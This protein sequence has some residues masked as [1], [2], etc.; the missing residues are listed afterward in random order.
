MELREKLKEKIQNTRILEDQEPEMESKAYKRLNGLLERNKKDPSIINNDKLM[1]ILTEYT[2]V[3]NAYEKISK[4]KGADTPGTDPN[5]IADG[6]N[7]ETLEKL[8]DDIK[9]GNFQWSNIRKINIPKPKS[10]KTRPLGMINNTDKIVQEMIRMVLNAIYEPVFQEYEWNHGFRPNRGANTA[11]LKIK[12]E[13]KGMTSAIEGDIKGA[14]VNRKILLNILKKKITDV[15]FLKLIKDGLEAGVIEDG[16]LIHSLTGVPQGGIASPILFNIYMHEFDTAITQMLDKHLKEINDREQ[17]QEKEAE[18][19]AHKE[20]SAEVTKH[21]RRIYAIKKK[22]LEKIN[23]KIGINPD[24]KRELTKHKK[25]YDKAIS[26]RLRTKAIS[27]KRKLL[28]ASYT[29]YADHWIITT[30]ASIEECRSIKELIQKWLKEN[31]KLELNEEKTLIT[32]LFKEKARFLGFKIYRLKKTVTRNIK[33]KS[34]WFREQRSIPTM[35]GIDFERVL[36]KLEQQ[37]IVV[38]TKKGYEPTH[39]SH[40]LRQK[41]YEIVEHYKHKLIGLIN[42][43][44]EH[45]D[46]R[47]KL[48]YIHHILYSSLKKTLANKKKTS[49]KGIVRK[50]GPEIRVEKTTTFKL[51]NGTEKVSKQTTTFPSYLKSVSG[52]VKQKKIENAIL[53]NRMEEEKK[54]KS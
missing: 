36:A 47:S 28:R 13:A 17:R 43:Y 49:S 44:Y 31:L 6:K 9:K 1:K 41:D 23:N 20:I 48:S 40:L 7:K 3:V 52:P 12:A 21:R 14:N 8:I 54:R 16:K 19:K 10:K 45:I 53:R 50:L 32:D 26:T 15:K 4:N 34:G 27:Q 11:I 24:D 37:K 33:R 46:Y 25:L 42:Y 18:S 30:N 35:I 38:K 22:N 2:M 5:E 39:V 29:R 51:K